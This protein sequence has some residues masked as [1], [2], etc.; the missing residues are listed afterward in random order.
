MAVVHFDSRQIRRQGYDPLYSNKETSVL[1]WLERRYGAN[2]FKEYSSGVKANRRCWGLLGDDHRNGSANWW[3]R[4]S[5]QKQQSV[6]L[7]RHSYLLWYIIRSTDTDPN[8]H[9]HSTHSP[10]TRP[11]WVPSSS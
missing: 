8:L 9:R 7:L 5:F 4:M 1:S 6:A 10:S 2:L 3:A 11:S